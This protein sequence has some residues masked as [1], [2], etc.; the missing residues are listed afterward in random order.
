[1]FADE[2]K[3][4]WLG[5]WIRDW[6]INQISGSV[7]KWNRLYNFIYPLVFQESPDGVILLPHHVGHQEHAVAALHILQLP[8]QELP[9]CLAGYS[10]GNDFAALITPSGRTYQTNKLTFSFVPNLIF[11]DH[12]LNKMQPGSSNF[13]IQN[14]LPELMKE[15]VILQHVL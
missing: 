4:G 13:S 2:F 3:L 11:H 5:Y 15:Q 7:C 6:L 9:G 12:Y 14:V 8:A 1:M 10:A